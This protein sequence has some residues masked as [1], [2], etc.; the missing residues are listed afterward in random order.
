MEQKKFMVKHHIQ[1]VI[2]T[3]FS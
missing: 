3:Q 1:N 2:A